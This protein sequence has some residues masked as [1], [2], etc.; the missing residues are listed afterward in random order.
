MQ[1]VYFNKFGSENVYLAEDFLFKKKSDVIYTTKA[2][3]FLWHQARKQACLENLQ[4]NGE[5]AKCI[6]HQRGE[7]LSDGSRDLAHGLGRARAGVQETP[8]SASEAPGSSIMDSSA[9]NCISSPFKVCCSLFIF[10]RYFSPEE[11]QHFVV[12]VPR[13]SLLALGPDKLLLSTRLY[14]CWKTGDLTIL[15]RNKCWVLQGTPT[16]PRALNA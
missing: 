5:R 2:A 6:K 13:T 15:I 3:H 1:N 10:R 16:A 14:Y 11:P 7:G 8:S 12:T 4:L 9:F